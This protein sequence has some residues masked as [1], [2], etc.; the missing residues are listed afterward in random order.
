MLNFIYILIIAI[1]SATC[2]SAKDEVELPEFTG[3]LAVGGETYVALNKA[4]SNNR[5]WI[6]IGGRF[7]NF[8][9]IFLHREDKTLVVGRG[10]EVM[11]LGLARRNTDGSNEP[12]REESLANAKALLHACGTI[13]Q[14]QAL[15]RPFDDQL[16][17]G[18]NAVETEKLKTIRESPSNVGA[19]IYVTRNKRGG[20]HVHR[21]LVTPSKLEAFK[22]EFVGLQPHDW[23]WFDNEYCRIEIEDLLAR[24]AERE[25]TKKQS[26]L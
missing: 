26:N 13:A 4:R 3:F 6:R 23:E 17:R 18:L 11:L 21:F 25:L 5:E 12:R 9:I 22:S 19:R 24:Q 14:H 15:Y 16:E 2:A 7:S 8:D 20:L 1:A 10:S